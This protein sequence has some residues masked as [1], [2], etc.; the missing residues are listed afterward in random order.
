MFYWT[1]IN[2]SLYSDVT[3][4]SK[5]NEKEY[6]HHKLSYLKLEHDESVEEMY[7]KVGVTMKL[8]TCKSE[9]WKVSSVI[10]VN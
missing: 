4:W 1:V 8:G 2:F 10:L 5:L 6:H 9:F 3:L 7:D